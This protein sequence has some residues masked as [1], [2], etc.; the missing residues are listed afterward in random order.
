MEA[1]GEAV[2]N[3]DINTCLSANGFVLVFPIRSSG[4]YRL[5]G[6]VPEELEGL[7]QEIG[8]G[9]GDGDGS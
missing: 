2:N 4:M 9:T 8:T 3:A 7:A 1:T 6:V 5:I